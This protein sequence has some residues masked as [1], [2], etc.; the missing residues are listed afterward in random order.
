MMITQFTTAQL[1][2]KERHDYWQEVVCNTFV[3]L[4]CTLNDMNDFSASLEIRELAEVKVVSIEASPQLVER[5]KEHRFSCSDEYILL[6]L[7]QRG[8][9]GIRQDNREVTL[10]AGEFSLYDTRKPYQLSFTDP[11]KQ[12]VVRIPYK[13]V[14]DRTGPIDHLTARPFSNQQ[15]FGRLAYDFFM[16]VAALPAGQSAKTLGK[17]AEQSIDLLAMAVSPLL[18]QEKATTLSR[19]TLL[20]RIKQHIAT[21]LDSPELTLTQVSQFFGISSR[22]VNQL[23]NDEQTSF[24]RYVLATRL[25]SCAARLSQTH[26]DH[27][28]VSS[29]AYRFGFYDMAYFS[30]A[31]KA[32]FGITAKAYRRESRYPDT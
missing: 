27:L 18:H 29:I 2:P 12:I 1:P 26:Y 10:S 6:S 11:F 25:E 4:A 32:R 19:N 30:R 20:Y 16:G 5:G 28:T 14:I 21:H 23:F 9:A 17:I 8:R 24:G 22:Y 7:A 3:P 31:F 13:A 15:P